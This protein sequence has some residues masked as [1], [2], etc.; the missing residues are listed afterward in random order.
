MA[1]SNSSYDCNYNSL[2]K[3]HV[4]NISRNTVKT[5]WELWILHCYLFSL[6]FSLKGMANILKRSVVHHAHF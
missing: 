3:Y 5:L 4:V 1:L 6:S 2:L